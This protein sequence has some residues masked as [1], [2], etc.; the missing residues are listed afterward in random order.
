MTV[1]TSP[2]IS[3]AGLLREET[4]MARCGGLTSMGVFLCSIWDDV[5]LDFLDDRISLRNVA[6]IPC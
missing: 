5:E 3:P 2:S 1:P 6:S 4:L